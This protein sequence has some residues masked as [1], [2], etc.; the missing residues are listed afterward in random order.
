MHT[1]TSDPMQEGESPRP[2]LVDE[3]LDQDVDWIKD[4]VNNVGPLI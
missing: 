1:A 2:L 3:G 4:D